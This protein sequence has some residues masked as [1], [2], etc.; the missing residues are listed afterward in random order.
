MEDWFPSGAFARQAYKLALLARLHV[1]G[2]TV[3]LED[4]RSAIL[5]VHAQPVRGARP[6]EVL[7]RMEADGGLRTLPGGTRFTRMTLAV[8]HP[9]VAARGDAKEP[10]H[11]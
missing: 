6:G 4:G 5:K 8:S 2:L 7:D 1:D 9:P 10:I 3:R 11:A